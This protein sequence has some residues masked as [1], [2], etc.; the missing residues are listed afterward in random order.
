MDRLWGQSEW[1]G[2][3]GLSGKPE[4]VHGMAG[5]AGGG[6]GGKVPETRG[7]TGLSIGIVLVSK[8]PCLS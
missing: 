2:N 4:S 7:G 3:L 1:G 6:L 8:P 5:R